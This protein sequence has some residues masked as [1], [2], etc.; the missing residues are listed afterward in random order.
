MLVPVWSWYVALV[1]LLE[2]V[3]LTVAFPVIS[4][5]SRTPLNVR[6]AIPVPGLSRRLSVPS[7]CEH[8]VPLP[9]LGDP[10]TPIESEP[11]PGADWVPVDVR[12]MTGSVE[13]ILHELEA[14]VSA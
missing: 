4:R 11:S 6:F 9:L 13:L 2:R 1:V 8:G 3:S 7:T 12:R 14:V 10:L 5:S